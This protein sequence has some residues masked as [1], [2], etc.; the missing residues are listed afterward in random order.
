[1]SDSLER[2]P[3]PFW[4]DGCGERSPFKIKGSRIPHDEYC[5]RFGEDAVV[6]WEK[7]A[8]WC[9]RTGGGIP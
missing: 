1:M 5:D 8:E 2:P 3:H 7:A 6:A 4:C 9:R